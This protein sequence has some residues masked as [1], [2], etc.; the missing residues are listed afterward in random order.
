MFGEK[1]PVE[2]EY[3]EMLEITATLAK[4]LLPQKR[5]ERFSYICHNTQEKNMSELL[6]LNV[7]VNS[8]QRKR[9]E[10]Q[11]E[12]FKS[13]EKKPELNKNKEFELKL[14]KVPKSYLCLLEIICNENRI[15]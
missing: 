5:T 8:N 3:R 6:I 2:V 10:N 1:K 14:N 9:K 15:E 13:E 12:N 11:N 7:K 4:D